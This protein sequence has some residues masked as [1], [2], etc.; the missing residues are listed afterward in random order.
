MNHPELLPFKENKTTVIFHCV[1]CGKFKSK[2]STSKYC[3][4]CLGLW[5]ENAIKIVFGVC[6][7]K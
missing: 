3:K 5:V 6:G 2:K 4:K 7:T 1:G